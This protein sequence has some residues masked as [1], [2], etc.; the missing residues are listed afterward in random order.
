MRKAGWRLEA[1]GWRPGAGETNSHSHHPVLSSSALSSSGLQPP[2]SSLPRRGFTLVELLITVSV[3][4][5]M[6]T[7]VLFALF[8]AQE[9]AKAQK[10]KSLIAKLDS[11]IKAKYETYKTRRVNITLPAPPPVTDTTN[12]PLYVARVARARL[13]CLHDLMRMEMPDR[14][15]DVEDI[16][17]TFSYT[18]FANI[19]V[20]RPS[21]HRSYKRKYDAIVTRTSPPPP[22]AADVGANAGAEC[23]YMIIMQAQGE[24][25]DDKSAIKQ[26]QIG[27]VD[28]DGFPEIID[29]WGRPI[30]FLRWAPG[31]VSELQTTVT[32]PTQNSNPSNVTSQSRLLSSVQGSYVGGVVINEDPANPGRYLA[33]SMAK[34]TGYNF[35]PGP[36]NVPGTGSFDVTGTTWSPPAPGASSFFVTAPDPFDPRGVQPLS[37]AIYPLIYSSGPDKCYGICADFDSM[38]PLHYSTTPVNDNPFY[39]GTDAVDGQQRLIGSP[40]DDTAELSF[41]TRAWV[42]N[43]HNHMITAR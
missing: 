12:Y 9:T 4:A 43:I 21:V 36:P 39:V 15:T 34:I 30:K 26:D 7:M 11:I 18:G 6:A 2:A 25:G 13:D 32:L 24:E 31:F 23:L 5:I 35:T 1:G 28:G 17:K 16:Q 20:V 29:A 33:S 19:G 42:D 3:I 38:N 10:T 40:R 8:A 37:F 22:S 41:V 27:D 14:W